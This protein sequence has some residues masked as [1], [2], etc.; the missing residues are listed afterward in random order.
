MIDTL[1]LTAV[2]CFFRH[3]STER[4]AHTERVYFLYVYSQ[5]L[6]QSLTIN[7]WVLSHFPHNAGKSTVLKK[8]S[9][10]DNDVHCH[11]LDLSVQECA[12]LGI[13]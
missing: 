9:F 4:E 12:D 1:P 13:F 6:L 7:K 3:C 8:V 10:V 2:Q 11:L 5:P